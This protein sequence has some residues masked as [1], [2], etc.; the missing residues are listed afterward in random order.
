MTGQGGV[1]AEAT[2][3]WDSPLGPGRLP[4]QP[5]WTLPWADSPEPLCSPQVTGAKRSV[6]K[7]WHEVGEQDHR[8][9]KGPDTP[10]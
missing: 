7:P 2:C 4:A 10:T 8:Q 5:H 9:K 1:W 3:S 6:E